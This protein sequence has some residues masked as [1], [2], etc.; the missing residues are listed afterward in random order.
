[1][2]HRS[3]L[4]LPR[5]LA[6]HCGATGNAYKTLE[7]LWRT[8][9]ALGGS[10]LPL[11]IQLRQT[12]ASAPDGAGEGQG[13][14]AGTVEVAEFVTPPSPG[15]PGYDQAHDQG[16][17]AGR[18][19]TFTLGDGDGAPTNFQFSERGL[20]GAGVKEYAL[21]GVVSHVDDAVDAAEHGHLV[22]HVKV[23]EGEAY[24]EFTTATAGA[25]EDGG[26]PANRGWL[27]INDFAL[28]STES[29]D[30]R[31]FHHEVSVSMKL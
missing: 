30:A 1:M 8:P 11:R 6:L 22:T 12:Y 17:D 21:V 23:A 5:V 10:F 14:E 7:A 15:L 4:T 13:A 28:S 2:Q 19:L 25:A 9:N 26:D 24:P 20:E 16:A 27:M 18:W 3:P 29:A 31:A